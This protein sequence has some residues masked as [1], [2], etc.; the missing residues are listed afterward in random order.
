MKKNS[1]VFH[2]TMLGVIKELEKEDIINYIDNVFR[3]NNN[4]EPIFNNNTMKIL[5]TS[6]LPL[7]EA[8]KL[9]YIKKV[10][11]GRINGKKGGAPLGNNNASKQPKTT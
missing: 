2:S 6:I 5:Y 10:E 9:R 7:I 1:I 3:C 11:N 4:E 8:D